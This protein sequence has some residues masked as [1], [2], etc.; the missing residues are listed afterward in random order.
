MTDERIIEALLKLI[1]TALNGDQCD[2]RFALVIWCDCRDA[3]FF[4]GSNQG[5]DV[6]DLA[7]IL[8]QASERVAHGAVGHA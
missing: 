4:V 5:N 2:V 6:P 3:P 1:D 7:N 8:K